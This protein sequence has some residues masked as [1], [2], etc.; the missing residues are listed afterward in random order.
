MRQV[1]KEMGSGG[2]L[3]LYMA[4]GIFG[5]VVLLVLHP[6]GLITRHYQKR[7]WR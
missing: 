7:P 4:A 5:F 2:F 1:E 3:L 6:R